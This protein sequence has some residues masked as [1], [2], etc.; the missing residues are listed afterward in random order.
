MIEWRPGAVCVKLGP[1]AGGTRESV[2]GKSALVT[3]P[4]GVLLA[5][6]DAKGSVRFAPEIPEKRE[7]CRGLK[8][9]AVAKLLMRF[10]E[11]FWLDQGLGDLAFLHAP[12]DLFPTWWTQAPCSSTVLTGW[13]GG[14]AAE[15]IQQMPGDAV[16]SEALSA[17]ARLFAVDR[18]AI[19]ASL[20]Q[21]HLADWT[22]D[23]YS[24]GAY[25]Y[26]AVGGED[27]A[28]QL[29]QPVENTLFF[30]GE[31]THDYLNGTVAGAIASGVWA[32][33]KIL[34]HGEFT[35]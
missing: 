16:L 17:L 12:G 21:W 32:A 23:P 3:I 7:A 28:R 8:M 27:A 6:A 33:E 22:G 25:S 14:P 35:I 11:P 19:A 29:R 30:A 26:V 20:E 13:A 31:H 18:A 4:L 24:R 15:R 9:G 5:S 2:E 1:E 10:R 34:A